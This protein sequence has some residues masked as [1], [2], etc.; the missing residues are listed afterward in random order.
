MSFVRGIHHVAIDVEAP[1][2]QVQLLRSFGLDAIYAFSRRGRYITSVGDP[3]AS[4]N[5]DGRPRILLPI[6][7]VPA[8][9]RGRL[10]HICFDVEDVDEAVKIIKNNGV[11]IDEED[12]D[13]IYGPEGLVFQIDSTTKPRREFTPR[14]P[15]RDAYTPIAEYERSVGDRTQ[16]R[17]DFGEATPYDRPAPDNAGMVTGIEHVALDV[18]SPTATRELSQAG[19]WA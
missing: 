10:N 1:T 5:E 2:R 4:R 19:V 17:E 15:K 11:D 6:F 13:R 12:A 18:G 16:V 3:T 8:L 9:R 7:Y 14:S